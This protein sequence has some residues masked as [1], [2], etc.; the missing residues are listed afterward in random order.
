M[1]ILKYVGVFTPE[2]WQGYGY[3]D[4]SGDVLRSV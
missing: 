3:G 4:E 1:R 2:P